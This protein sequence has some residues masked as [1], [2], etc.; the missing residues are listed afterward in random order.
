M[1]SVPA[2]KAL[3]ARSLGWRKAGIPE[4]TANTAAL[5]Y[6]LEFAFDI[7]NLAAK[8]KWQPQNVAAIF[9][10]VGDRLAIDTART[11]ARMTRQEGHFDRLAAFRLVEELSLRQAA[12]AKNIIEG[13]DKEPTGDVKKWLEPLLKSWRE[14]HDDTI[15]RYKLFAADLNLDTDLSV[16]KLSLLNQKLLDLIDRTR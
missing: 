9:F 5:M 7:V 12:I 13:T 10:A 3:K 4:E 14:C 15:N 8:T 11:A 2:A 16:G 1:L 6:S